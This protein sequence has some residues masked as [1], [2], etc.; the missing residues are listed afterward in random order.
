MLGLILIDKPAGVTSHDVVYRVRKSLGTKKV[1]HAG[2]LDPLA[3]GLLVVAVGAATR[4]LRYLALDPKRYDFSVKFG[5]ETDTYDKDGQVVAV[6]TVPEDLKAQIER[7]LPSFVGDIEQLPPM[8]SAVKK[9]GLPLYKYARKGQDVERAA[10][11]VTVHSLELLSPGAPVWPRQPSKTTGQESE[12]AD[13]ELLTFRCV[14]STGTYVRSIA[15]DLGQAIGCGAHVVALDRTAV[16]RFH[17]ER[18]VGLDDITAKRIIP[19]GEALAPMP[20]ITVKDGAVQVLRHGNAL[21]HPAPPNAERV[22]IQD[23]DGEIVC[24]ARVEAN[25]LQPECVVPVEES[26]GKVH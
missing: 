21:K 26:I 13:R 17:K 9:D 5:E 8:Y 18:A 2:T 20:L 16:G 25:G 19:L 10:R 1:G 4:F 24:V 6:R 7:L 14:C 23:E 15:H 11:T 12:A 22:A 3:T